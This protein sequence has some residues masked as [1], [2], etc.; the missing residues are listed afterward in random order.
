MKEGARG[1]ATGLV[2]R[3]VCGCVCVCVCV[4]V[5]VCVCVCVCVCHLHGRVGGL[6][7]DEQRLD[8]AA[9]AHALPALV[10]LRHVAE[11]QR[12]VPPHLQE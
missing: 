12:R 9:L 8:A 4:Y 6:E 2:L 5:Y 10:V 7:H 11:H 1:S 3:G